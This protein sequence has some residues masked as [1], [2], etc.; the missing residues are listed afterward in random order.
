MTFRDLLFVLW[1]FLPAGLANMM[2]VFTAKLPLLRTLDFPLD[3]DATFHGKRAF[4]DPAW[5][6]DEAEGQPHL[7]CLRIFCVSRDRMSGAMPQ[8]AEDSIH[9]RPSSLCLRL[10]GF[11]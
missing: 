8:L 3:G 7:S 1:F 6:L 2:P 5:L 11:L 9:D 10:P 4:G